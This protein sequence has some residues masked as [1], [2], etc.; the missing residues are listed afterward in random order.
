M[1]YNEII[2]KT[3]DIKGITIP[4]MKKNVWASLKKIS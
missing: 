3:R 4:G 1:I 2:T